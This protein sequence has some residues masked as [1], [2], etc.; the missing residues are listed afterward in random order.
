MEIRMREKKYERKFHV[1]AL[2][3]SHHGR[4]R[5]QEEKRK[6]EKDVGAWQSLVCLVKDTNEPNGF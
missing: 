2:G 3:K 6:K 4:E 5:K 1:P